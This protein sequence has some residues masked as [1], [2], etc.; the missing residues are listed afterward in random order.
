MANDTDFNH[1]QLGHILGDQLLE[2]PRFQRAYSW[3]QENVEEYLADLKA[4]RSRGDAYFMGTA[5]FAKPADPKDRLQVVDGQQRLATTAVFFMAIR[6]LL[7]EYGLAKQAEETEKQYLRGYALSAQAEVERLILSPKDVP[8]YNLLLDGDR[9]NAD[10]DHLLT[11]C[12]DVCLNHLREVAPT[13]KEVDLV[14]AVATQL[15]TRV[16][17]LVAVASGLSEAYVIFETLNDRG[18]DLTTADLLKNYL[19]SKAGAH[20]RYFEHSWVA[21]ESGFDKADDLVRFIRYEYA[22]RNGAVQ[23]RRLYRSIQTE[24]E[25]PGADARKYVE[26]LLKAR[27]VYRALRNP[28]DAYWST[29]DTDVRDALLAY[30]RFGFESSFPTLM[31]AFLKWT[32]PSA[33]KLLVKLSKWSV[34]AQFDGRIGGQQSEEA[35][36][37]A[38]VAITTGAATNQSAVRTHLAKLIPTD[39]TFKAAFVAYG[40][41]PTTRAKYVLAMLDRAAESKAGRAPRSVDWASTSYNIEHV[42]SNSAGKSDPDLNEIVGTIG[43]LAILEK[44]LNRDLGA[45]PF[46]AKKTNYATSDFELTKSLASESTWGRAEIE[47]RT[48][49]LAD[50]AVI[51]WPAH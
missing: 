42:Y 41:V 17:V 39:S 20:M 48:R 23:V 7:A 3:K 15:L 27:D 43:N 32:K 38:A 14:N 40:A 47:K 2:V 4:A 36:G 26:R 25:Q 46:S 1:D 51:A 19:F 29:Q 37:T 28:D 35:F 22:T 49:E 5:V 33:S 6:D 11:A 24:L 12:Y 8:T 34:R 30:R 44:K 16:Q 21:L 18:A 9:A 13:P 45:K 10:D 50:L 31:A